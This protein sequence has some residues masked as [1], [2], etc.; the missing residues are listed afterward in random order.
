MLK[1][2]FIEL[3]N[4]LGRIPYLVD[5]IRNH[6]I[7]PT[8]IIGKLN[9]YYAFL[10]KM[11]ENV[12]VLN[13]YEQRVLT[14]FSRELLDGKRKHELILVKSLL[15]TTEITKQAYIHELDDNDCLIDTKIFNSIERVMDL[16]FFSQTDKKKYGD[17][18]I[19][20]I[21]SDEQY[22][23]NPTVRNSLMRNEYFQYLVNDL[24]EA[25]LERSRKYKPDSLLTINEK[26]TRKDAC[27]LLN[28]DNDESSTMYGY[29]PKHQTCPIF[30]TYHKDDVESSVDYGDAFISPDVFK[31][32]TRSNR[33][34]KSKEVQKIIQA[35]AKGIDIHLFIKKD[36]DEGSDFY[37]IGEVVP[38]QQTVEEDT[39]RDKK[40]K[41]I[42]V[43]HM[44]MILEKP[45]EHD[46]YRYIT[47]SNE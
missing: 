31:W 24:V 32:Y 36:D 30:V 38:N 34:L 25:G 18:P 12:P 29:K 22:T 14:M 9:T 11:K 6:S 16:S 15:N 43:V 45:V 44:N 28:W 3:K 19:I 13:D 2:A 40:N 26:Y 33:T 1:E 8:V 20:T 47:S 35:E 23:F 10:H 42:P 39:M 46:L 17:N 41:E 27:K 4:R 7:D 5:F 21:S 37:Y